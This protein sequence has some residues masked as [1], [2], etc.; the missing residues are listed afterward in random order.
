MRRP[1]MFCVFLKIF[2]P[3]HLSSRSLVGGSEPMKGPV[4]HD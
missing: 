3:H 4:L 1:S 2:W